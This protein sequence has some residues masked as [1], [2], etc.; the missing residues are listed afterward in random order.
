MT[1]ALF[2]LDNTLL[3]DDSDH[4]WGRFL[5]ARGI[6]DAE[7]HRETNDR[8]QREYERGEL[9]IE[10]FL[11]FALQ[12][13]ADNDP[14][15]LERWR[16]E[17]V[18]DWIEPIVA[19]A[20]GA[21]IAWHR[22]RGHTLVTVTATNRFITE[23]IVTRLG[24]PHLIAT[25]PEIRNGRFTGH[26]IGT[27]TFQEGKIDALEKWCRDTDE[28]MAGAWFYS[29]SINDLPLLEHVAR[30]HVVD[31]DGRLDGAALE[32]GWPRLTLRAGPNPRELTG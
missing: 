31:P 30:P 16:S 20:A 10:A 24:I 2:D 7:H 6:V 29:D 26:Y 22:E 11:R 32:R 25:E 9:D 8:F 13:L 3:T 4:L 1:L 18:R 5:E 21:L 23:P 28:P 19:P 14:S 12:P 27:P 15:D 17:F